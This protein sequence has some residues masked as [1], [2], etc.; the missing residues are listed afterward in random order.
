M[1]WVGV[2]VVQESRPP[3]G[4]VCVV[5]CMCTVCVVCVHYMCTMYGVCVC[6][7]CVYMC[8][9]CVCIVCVCD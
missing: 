4:C 9:V 2:W 8:A 1:V 6:F 7:M 3:K 5:Y